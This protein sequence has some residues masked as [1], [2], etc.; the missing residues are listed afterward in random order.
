MFT[1]RKMVLFGLGVWLVYLAF[2]NPSFF[3]WDGHGML[4]VAISLVQRHSLSVPSGFG[5]PGRNGQFYSMWY[6]LLSFLAVPFVCLGLLLSGLFRLPEPYT[7]S[8]SA[9]VLSTVIAAGTAVA[10]ALLA[11]RLGASHRRA[12][13]AGV[14]YAFCTLAF[15]YARDFYADPLLALLVT[16]GLFFALSKTENWGAGICC[17]LAIL[18]KPTGILL[19][20]ALAVY[21]LALRKKGLWRVIVGGGLGVVAF[22]LWDYLCFGSPFRVGQ[23]NFWT[24][25]HIVPAFVGLL[26]SPGVGLF[27]YC[28]LLFLALPRIES[29][30][31]EQRLILGLSLLFVCLHSFWGRW[32]ASDWGPRFLLPVMPGLTALAVLRSRRKVIA[33]LALVGFLIQIPTLFSTPDRYIEVSLASGV[34]Q[35]QLIWS[36]LKS[37]VIGAWPSAI[38]QVKSAA[39]AGVLSM[40]TYRPAST[41]ISEARFLRI[42][43]L[44]WWMLP[45][46]GVS[47]WWGVLASCALLFFGLT[48]IRF[49]YRA[50]VKLSVEVVAETLP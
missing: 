19:T 45:I 38:A 13:F 22:M 1:A 14:I 37:P 2:L 42:V 4:D 31:K 21:F 7:V 47:R 3:S 27:V 18:A 9:V 41:T 34:S 6:P 11:L 30:H 28:P 44:W 16:L 23:P 15:T 32:Y 29:I 43:P 26:V 10:T 8:L 35:E 39:N 46:I 33:T 48:L 40:R 17:L 36:P 5:A 12:V 50:G 49:V 25:S 20:A 24:V